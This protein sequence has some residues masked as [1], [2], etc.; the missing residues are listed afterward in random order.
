MLLQFSL[1]NIATGETGI[2]G[3]V[4][5]N[6]IA[7]WNRWKVP[8]DTPGGPGG[9]HRTLRGKLITTL[10]MKTGATHWSDETFDA[11]SARILEA[12]GQK[13]QAEIH[14]AARAGEQTAELQSKKS[15]LAV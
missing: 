7:S 10:N 13:D 2:P 11:V 5:V 9:L 8:D 14:R 1:V 12:R 15:P 6:E 3:Y 4:D